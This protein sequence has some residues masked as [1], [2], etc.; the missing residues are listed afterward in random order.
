MR[1]VNLGTLA[2]NAYLFPTLAGYLLVDTGY[3]RRGRG[4]FFA[5]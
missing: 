3:P 1:P 2:V 4:V 5:G